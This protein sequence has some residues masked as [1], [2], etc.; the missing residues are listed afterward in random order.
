MDSSVERR[1]LH[2]VDR[3]RRR[4]RNP[5]VRPTAR[6]TTLLT[7]SAP[8]TS[9]PENARPSTQ[10]TTTPSAV[11]LDLGH[12]RALRRPAAPAGARA[13]Q[14]RSV[15]LG[16]AQGEVERLLARGH[17]RVAG[18][19]LHA[20]AADLVDGDLRAQVLGERRGSGGRRRS[21]CR[22]RKAC[23]AGSASCR[24]RARRRR[25]GPGP[26]RRASRPGPP[27]TTITSASRRSA[28]GDRVLQPSAGTMSGYAG[29]P[30][31]R[32]PLVHRDVRRGHA[33]PARGLGGDRLRARH[34]DRGAD[35]LGQD[36]GRLPVGARPP[37]PA[38]RSRDAW[39]TA[40]TSSTSRR[41]AR[42]TTTSRRTCASR[43]PASAP[44]PP[45]TA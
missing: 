30:P 27:P 14:Q 25:A 32:P 8:M 31:V 11:A 20:H 43:W 41:C 6:A 39:R 1:L 44:R 38:R 17:D 10:R 19:R 33:A 13:G 29:V 12:P 4:P 42:S 24:G 40:S 15:E 9:R 3:Q 7:P 45:P 35:R 34:A 36:A 18:R 23:R 22:R 26:A 2:G 5:A 16:A 28:H 21:G 37:A